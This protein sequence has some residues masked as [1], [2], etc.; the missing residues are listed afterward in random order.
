MGHLMRSR[1]VATALAMWCLSAPA[2]H[3]QPMA[4]IDSRFRVLGNVAPND[5]RKTR[6][7]IDGLRIV[8][9]SI[10]PNIPGYFIVSNLY[11]A[12]EKAADVIHEAAMENDVKRSNAA[13][14]RMW[15]SRMTCWHGIACATNSRATCFTRGKNSCGASMRTRIC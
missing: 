4:V 13:R 12:S 6:Y 9:A 15:C 8:D 11:M 3:A 2:G 5:P 14:G 7:P 10:F 1:F